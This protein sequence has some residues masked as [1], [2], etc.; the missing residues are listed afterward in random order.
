MPRR[1]AFSLRGF[2]PAYVWA[3]ASHVM[4]VWKLRAYLQVLPPVADRDK[5]ITLGDDFVLHGE[6]PPTW[7]GRG[8][9]ALLEQGAARAHR[10]DRGRDVYN[11][12]LLFAPDP[13]HLAIDLLRRGH[14]ARRIHVDDDGLDGIVIGKFLK[15]RDDLFRRENYAIEIDDSNLGPEAGKRFFIVPAKAQVDQRKDG[16]YEQR[17]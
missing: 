15:L 2:V 6:H 10:L 8:H 5:R 4:G 16:D 11:A 13:L 14:A 9:R 7:R 1:R 12:F 17:T 3:A